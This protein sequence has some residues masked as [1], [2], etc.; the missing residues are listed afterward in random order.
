M[1]AAVY[2]E[3]GGPEVF[4]YEEVPDPVAQ[5]GEVLLRIEAIGVQGGDLLHRQLAPV[6]NAPHIVGYQAAGT[7]VALGDGVTGVREGQR[8][9]AF[10]ASGSHAELAAVKA[11]N[12]YAVPDDMDPRVAA[13]ILI[14]FATAD[15]CLFEFGRL[16]AGETVLV[17]A[18]A[19]GVGLAAVQLA[20]AAGATVIG[21][22]SSDEKLG[23]LARYGLDHA[24]NYRD[25]DVVARVRE[26]TG[27]RGADLVLDPVGGR[28]L[29]GSIE[30][31]AYRGRISWIGEAGREGYSPQVRPLMGKSASLNGVYLAAEMQ[32]DPARV[33]TMVDT[34]IARIAAGELTV[35]VDREFPLAEAAD[36]HRFIE[37]REAFGRVLLIP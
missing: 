11:R 29:E 14:E 27:G 8:V 6:Q 2:Y 1:K 12:A 10:M 33:R 31:L 37:N 25:E 22:A 5:A 24:I 17:Q 34:L 32:H 18:A 4:R 35:V 3:N 9:V 26:L 36:A 30:A 16:R 20:K 19:G 7:I 28:T 13:G 21:T 15:D 23:R